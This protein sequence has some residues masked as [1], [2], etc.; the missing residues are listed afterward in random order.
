MERTFIFEAPSDGAAIAAFSWPAASRPRAVVQIAHGLAEHAG[1]YRRLA[2]ALNA[3]GIA[4][5]A[6]DHRGHGASIAPGARPGDFGAGGWEGLVEDMAALTSI[7]RRE[8]PEAP[9]ILLGHSMGSFAAQ[10]YLLDRSGAIDACALSGSSDLPSLVELAMSG[11]DMSFAAFNKPF[12]PARTAFDWLSRDPAEVDAYVNDPLCGFEA[13]PET[14]FAIMAP[15]A[16]YAEP[17]GLRSVRRDIPIRIFSGADDPLCGGGAL[18]EKL[19]GR[20]RNAGLERVTTKLYEG[21]RHEMFNEI[22]RDEVT[23]DLIDWIAVVVG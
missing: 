15:A 11:A 6:N 5:Y 2:A 1:R 7:I 23:R 8:N 19:A 13:P 3:A 4:A 10:T 22:N 12:E 17:N 18:I 21:G 14:A 16:R 20:Y 9:V